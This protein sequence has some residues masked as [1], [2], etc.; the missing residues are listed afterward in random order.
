MK[1]VT[2]VIYEVT[3][4]YRRTDYMGGITLRFQG[5]WMWAPWFQTTTGDV[6]C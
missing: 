3:V 6:P 2:T 4:E 1:D 5:P